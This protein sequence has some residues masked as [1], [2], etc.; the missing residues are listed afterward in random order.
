[1]T[2]IPLAIGWYVFLIC[3]LWA[4]QHLTRCFTYLN[5]FSLFVLFLVIR[6]GI[7]VPFD[8]DVN[9]WFA[10]ISISN[11]ALVRF[12]VSLVMMYLF[13]LIGIS[14]GIH[15]FGN[16]DIE[17]ETFHTE[18]RKKLLP[19]GINWALFLP[20]LTIGVGL[21]V[22]YHLRSTYSLTD[23]LSGA[24]SA[25]D[26]RMGRIEYGSEILYSN[27]WALRLASISR[28]GLFPLFIFTL[29]FLKE[30]HTAW[31]GLFIF[32]LV[33]GIVA[34][35]LSG[36]KSPAL[37]LMIGLGLAILLRKGQLRLNLLDWRILISL[38]V[39]ILVILPFLY[40][41]Q[42][43]YLEYDQALEATFYRLTSEYDRSLQLY[44]EIYPDVRPFQY[45]ASASLIN[46]LLGNNIPT[47]MLP[48]RFI[49]T[50]YLGPTYPNTWNAVFVGY[51]WADF[52][53]VGVVLESVI[54][55]ILL[56]WDARWFSRAR[57]TALVM[58]TQVSLMLAATKISEV[59]L[60]A[61]LLSFGLLS[62]FLVYVIVRKYPK[63]VLES[64][65]I[66]NAD[67]VNRT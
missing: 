43:P 7:T 29:Y 9:W 10:R 67:N 13:L 30:R 44:F 19:A 17:P 4:F 54:V 50:Y 65:Q 21:V 22:V 5:V 38:G 20:V 2:S 46:S 25:S 55:G 26:Y 1:M 24:L 58:G 3:V 32:V 53:F 23:L 11:E 63:H 16:A 34:G 64:R 49:P 35:L 36:Q 15:L 66:V 60:T 40:R 52:G 12:Y 57:K 41:L 45:G 39:G 6:Y 47:D 14:L 31:Y 42:Y 27:S 62:S 28:F 33:V 59:A 8:N 48:E 51:A 37:L 56:Q 18:M 61:G